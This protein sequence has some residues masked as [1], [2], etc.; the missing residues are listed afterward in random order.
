MTIKEGNHM[1]HR[2]PVLSAFGE[3]AE[4]LQDSEA[5]ARDPERKAAFLDK[6]KF[7]IFYFVISLNDI[8]VTG[9][10]CDVYAGDPESCD[11]CSADLFSIGFFVDGATKNGGWANMCPGCLAKH[12]RGIGWGIGQFYRVQRTSDGEKTRWVMIAGGNPFP[13]ED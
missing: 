9:G 6:Y 11:L 12:G 10:Q 7:E 4:A 2:K 8:M 13:E 3:F 1:Q 5:I